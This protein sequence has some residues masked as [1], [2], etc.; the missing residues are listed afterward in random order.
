MV[1]GLPDATTELKQSLHTRIT[2]W[3][4]ACSR[5]YILGAAVECKVMLLAHLKASVSISSHVVPACCD[6]L[7]APTRRTLGRWR[8]QSSVLSNNKISAASHRRVS[9]KPS[10]YWTKANYA[11]TQRLIAMASSAETSAPASGHASS[12]DEPKVGLPIVQPSH[13]T[14]AA[15]MPPPRPLITFQHTIR[16]TCS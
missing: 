15:R 16:I 10:I 12:S 9:P 8:N 1:P 14:C 4:V 7:C 13:A 6:T 2:A 5:Y 3:H 11:S